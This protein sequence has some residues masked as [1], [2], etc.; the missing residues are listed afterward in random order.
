MEKIAEEEMAGRQDRK[1][2]GERRGEKFT[3]IETIPS[4]RR[5]SSWD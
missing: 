3:T 4:A 1:R 2:C 5:T